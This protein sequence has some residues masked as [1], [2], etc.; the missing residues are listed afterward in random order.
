MVKGPQLR[1]GT[2]MVRRGAQRAA[3]RAGFLRGGGD[4]LG[5]LQEGRSVGGKCERENG[6]EVWW[7]EARG[8]RQAGQGQ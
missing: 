1:E 3:E 4:A 8:P 5:F 2:C 6:R 7:M